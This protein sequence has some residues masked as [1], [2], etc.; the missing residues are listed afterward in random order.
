MGHE[1][2]ETRKRACVRAEGR[3]TGIDESDHG[4]MAAIGG[5]RWLTTLKM[6]ST[7]YKLKRDAGACVGWP[8]IC[9]GLIVNDLIFYQHLAKLVLL[10][11]STWEHK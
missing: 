2:G 3:T 11:A 1:C 7:I 6:S 10:L 5:D 8:C 4:N 9:S